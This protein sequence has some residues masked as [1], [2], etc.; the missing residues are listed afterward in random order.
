M[1]HRGPT[2]PADISTLGG[3]RHQL[4][5]TRITF[6]HPCLAIA[7]IMPLAA[8]SWSLPIQSGLC[9]HVEVHAVTT[10][11]LMGIALMICVVGIAIAWALYGCGPSPTVT[12]LVDLFFFFFN[13]T[14][15]PKISPFPHHDPL[16]I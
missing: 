7:C 3:F 6:Q 10:M 4:P 11:V 14:A 2:T 12:R 1:Q 13:Y 8:L 15:P 16:P 5:I 9:I